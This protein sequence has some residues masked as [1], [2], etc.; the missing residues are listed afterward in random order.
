MN[1]L[2]VTQRAIIGLTL[3]SMFFGAGNLIFPPA[4]GYQAGEHMPMALIGFL[5]TAVGL[6]ILG[7]MTV[8]ES[9]GLDKLAGRVGPRFTFIFTLL[10]Y[11][12]IGPGVAVPRTASTSFEMTLLPIAQGLSPDFVTG[13]V[14]GSVTGEQVCLAIYSILFFTLSF[15]ASLKPEKLSHVF[16]KV[17]CPA[18]VILIAILF[19]GAWMHPVGNWGPGVEPYVSSAFSKG[20]IDGYQTMDTIAG[21]LFGLVVA[22]NIRSFGVTSE[23]GVM[24]E[25]IFAGIIAMVLFFL[26]YGALAFMGAQTSLVPNLMT[27]T[28]NLRYVASTLFGTPG[29]VIMGII[30][31]IACFNCCTGL[32]ACLAN[33][34]KSNVGGLGYKGWAFVFAFVSMVLSN[35]GLAMILKFSIPILFFIYPICIV[36]IALGLLSAFFKGL[37]TMRVTWIVTLL[38]TGVIS[39]LQAY[40]VATGAKVAFLA[41]LPLNESSL[42][43]V[44]PALV[45]FLIGGFLGKMKCSKGCCS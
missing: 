7:V 6:P 29:L 36:L 41:T 31:F 28:D 32:I 34:F 24:K 9:G 10:I 37:R 45:G 15:L 4:L 25:T 30:F 38:F 26:V 2:T 5:I 20:F 21:L 3:F 17:T 43:W 35:A 23:A 12:A 19:V 40:E 42:P 39:T 8:S 44:V 27:G 22:M 18:L 14:F 13:H 16:G 33:W 1:R 11:L